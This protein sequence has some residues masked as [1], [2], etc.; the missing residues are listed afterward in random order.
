MTE[1]FND[2]INNTM[3][4]N[5]IKSEKAAELLLEDI[6]S[7]LKNQNPNA[8]AQDFEKKM[9]NAIDYANKKSS[10]SGFNLNFQIVDENGDGKWNEGEKIKVHNNSRYFNQPKAFKLD[11]VLDVKDGV[12]GMRGENAQLNQVLDQ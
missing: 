5:D 6:H 7:T 10:D 1:N 3:K 12:D 2:R 11:G 4:G 8:S 9:N